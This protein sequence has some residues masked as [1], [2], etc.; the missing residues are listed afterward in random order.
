MTRK[1][2]QERRQGLLHWSAAGHLRGCWAR[3][4]PLRSSQTPAPVTRCLRKPPRRPPAGVLSTGSDGSSSNSE[5]CMPSLL[6]SPKP[7]R[8]SQRGRACSASASLVTGGSC[9]HGHCCVEHWA[10]TC[11]GISVGHSHLVLC[12][13]CRHGLLSGATRSCQPGGGPHLG[14]ARRLQADRQ[15]TRPR[16]EGKGSD[17]AWVLQRG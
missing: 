10:A 12:C 7:S 16:L 6:S 4:L 5:S 1:E 13:G 8:A 17:C 9:G 15:R 2:A 11:L 14:G 3:G